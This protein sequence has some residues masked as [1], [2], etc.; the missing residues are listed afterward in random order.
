MKS[1]H[2]L[3][4]LVDV[5]HNTSVAIFNARKEAIQSGNVDEEMVDLLSILSE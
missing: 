4:D 3:R 2:K 5:M 1:L